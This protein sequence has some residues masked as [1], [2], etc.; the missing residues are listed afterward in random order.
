M[1]KALKKESLIDRH[2]RWKL[3]IDANK[4]VRYC[5]GKPELTIRSIDSL[6]WLKWLW[7]RECGATYYLDP[8]YEVDASIKDDMRQGMKYLSNLMDWFYVRNHIH[9]EYR[10]A[11]TVCESD[12]EYI[13]GCGVPQ[14][15]S[16]RFTYPF[17]NESV[18]YSRAK[19]HKP[20]LTRRRANGL[21]WLLVAFELI[22]EDRADSPE[23][24]WIGWANKL[25]LERF[26]IGIQ[27]IKQL[28]Q[29][30]EVK[31]PTAR[32]GE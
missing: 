7:E 24:S 10:I 27:F 3:H 28:A 16:T 30:H 29:W 18:M 9:A 23:T 13:Q 25:Q 6:F 12:F 14:S 32:R 19:T 31:H 8:L 4:S 11:T 17:I 15:T 1:N 2:K 21:W 26:D 20:R 5:F 22:F